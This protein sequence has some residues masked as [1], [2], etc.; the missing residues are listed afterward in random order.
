MVSLEAMPSIYLVKM[1]MFGSLENFELFHKEK[2]YE[3][4]FEGLIIEEYKSK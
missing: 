2:H 1:A 4:K 3:D